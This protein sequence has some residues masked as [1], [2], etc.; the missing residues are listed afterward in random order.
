MT[1]FVS[2]CSIWVNPR[3]RNSGKWRGSNAPFNNNG[4]GLSAGK[5]TWNPKSWRFGS[6]DFPVHFGWFSGSTHVNFWE[7]SIHWLQ[8][9]I[10]T[11]AFQYPAVG[12]WFKKIVEIPMRIT[13]RKVLRTPSLPGSIRDLFYPRSL[14]VTNNNLWKCHCSPS[15]KGHKRRIARWKK[16]TSWSSKKIRS[17]SWLPPKKT[18]WRCREF[19]PF[20]PTPK[21]NSTN[22]E[23]VNKRP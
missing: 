18:C 16:K 4:L 1:G 17:L 5:L 10:T 22:C 12:D 13:R 3:P 21:K 6:D 7:C 14:K 23:I 9:K 19:L 15:Q 2:R 20:P 11:P 8:K